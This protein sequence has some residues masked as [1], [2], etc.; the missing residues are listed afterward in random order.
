MFDHILRD[1]NEKQGLFIKLLDER[2]QVL[3][4]IAY[5][6]F[7]NKDSASDVVQDSVLIAYKNIAKLKDRGKFNAWITTILVNRCR[8]IVRKNK[9]VNF[10]EYNENV[11]YINKL[12]LKNIDS[13]FENLEMRLDLIKVL[14]IVDDKYSEVIRLK[15]FGDYT[16]EEIATIIDIPQGTVKSRLSTG[17]K[18]LKSLMEVK[19]S[20]M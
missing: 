7:R 15:Y 12:C 3:Y 17:I 9:R 11:L 2:V 10:E 16:I 14:D 20:A 8:D 18:K 5:S 4:K 1:K 6:Y 19:K 13:S